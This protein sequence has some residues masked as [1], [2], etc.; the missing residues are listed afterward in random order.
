[1]SENPPTARKAVAIVQSNYIPWKGYFDIINMV[2]LFI[3]HDDLQYTKQ[4]WRNRNKI[5]TS[6]GTEWL[7]IPCGSD[8]NR[9]ICEVELWDKS[10]QRKHWHKITQYYQHAPY[11]ELYKDFFE[12]F[13][14][15]N[16]W[17]NLS[18]LNQYL[19]KKI[20]RLFLGINTEFDDSRRYNLKEKRAARMLELL[21][22]V[23][24]NEYLSG[25]AAKNYLDERQFEDAGIKLL[26]MDYNGYLEYD[27][28]YPPFV[29]NVSIIDLLFNVGEKAYKYLKSFDDRS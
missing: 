27:Q 24:V 8:E 22:K 7:S 26:W 9:L 15:H 1:M 13:Y 28:L 12:D 19:I 5:K 25:P 23:G 16:N 3:F 4:D 17:V 2:D 21:K 29:H 20:S 14:L 11:F 6:C 18:N 10:W